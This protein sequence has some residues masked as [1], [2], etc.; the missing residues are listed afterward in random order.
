M[1]WPRP[2]YRLRQFFAAL[3]P[4]LQRPELA[5]ARNL[6]GEDL[7]PLFRSMTLRDQRH[8]LDVLRYLRGQGCQDRDTLAAA[9]LHDIGKGSNVRMWERMTYVLLNAA[10]PSLLSRVNTGLARLRDHAETGGRMAAAAG[11]GPELVRLI[12]RHEDC[13]IPP[14]DRALFLLRM[15]DDAC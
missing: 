10:T 6:L 3:R 1:S 11:A 15:A 4:K 5:D 8:S 14:A 9:L 2:H 13:K 7:F 12:A